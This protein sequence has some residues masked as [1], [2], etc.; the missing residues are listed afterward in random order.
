MVRHKAIP[1]DWSWC[2]VMY[3]DVTMKTDRTRGDVEPGRRRKA[4]NFVE[5]ALRKVWP[6]KGLLHVRLERN[7]DWVLTVDTG[8]GSKLVIRGRLNTTRYSVEHVA[9]P[10]TASASGLSV[11]V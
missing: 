8:E 10:A 11:A 2:P 1:M 4:D 6:G 5:A 9:G 3:L 7:G